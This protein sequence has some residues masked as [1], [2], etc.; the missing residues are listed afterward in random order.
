[1]KCG[2]CKFLAMKNTDDGHPLD[3][4]DICVISGEEVD[5]NELCTIDIDAIR[6]Y[7]REL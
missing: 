1:M 6:E 3:W 2:I 7:L 5:P 4:V